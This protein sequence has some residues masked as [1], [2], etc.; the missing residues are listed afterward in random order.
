ML[1][2]VWLSDYFIDLPLQTHARARANHTN[3]HARK[4]DDEEAF[5]DVKQRPDKQSDR[6]DDRKATKVN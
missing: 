6:H 5:F 2:E 1:K 3:E 4:N